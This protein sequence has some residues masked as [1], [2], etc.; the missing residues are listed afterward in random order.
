MSNRTAKK[1]PVVRLPPKSTSELLLS[2][3]A[4]AAVIGVGF[5]ALV[6]AL[7]AGEYVLA[8]IALGVVIGLMFGPV[9]ARLERWGMRP[10]LSAAF[11][12]VLFVGI[13]G[14]FVAAVLTPLASWLERLPQIW[15][16]LQIKLYEW[17]EPLEALKNVREEIRG[18]TGSPDVTVAVED[19]SAVTSMATLAPA[20]VAQI[21]LFF[22]SLYFFV[23]T[24]H[25]M[26][27]GVLR[28]C[29]DRRLR[30]RVAH[31]FRDVEQLVSRYLLS[32]SIINV[33]EGA[34]VGLAL[35]A[36]GVPSAAMWGALAAL[37]NF[38]VYVGPFAMTLILFAVGLG[39]FDTLGG[40]LL[41]PLIYL[42]INAIEAQFVTPVV[43]GRAM[44]LNPFLVLLALVFW[45]WL[46]GP[47]GGFVAIPAVLVTFAIVRN[48][49][50]GFSRSDA[51]TV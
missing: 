7:H 1:A 37:T 18:I 17:R 36:I 50:P 8:P 35:F 22:A 43:I 31:I 14:A 20:V 13:V 47:L 24:R 29:V 12:L 10:G 25:Q 49:V 23:A 51:V 46:W 39:E 26:R 45:I 3:G 21:L 38:V 27:K 5:L 15:A 48:L 41:P 19:G 30:W 11:V 2:R 28:L 32:I 9:A 40:S 42:G 6:F 34:A 4:Q 33:L 16:E 44:T